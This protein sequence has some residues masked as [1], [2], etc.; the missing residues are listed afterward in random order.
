MSFLQRLFVLAVLWS[1]VALNGLLAL[2]E[3]IF[4]SRRRAG[5]DLDQG[6]AGAGGPDSA[7]TN[8]GDAP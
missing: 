5:T 7:H 8:R 1:G 6:G 3:W 2:G 4:A